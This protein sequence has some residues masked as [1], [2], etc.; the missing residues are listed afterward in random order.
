MRYELDK[1]HS[2]R[3]ELEENQREY[4]KVASQDFKLAFAKKKD[5]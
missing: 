5:V 1:N 3:E 4:L 2:I